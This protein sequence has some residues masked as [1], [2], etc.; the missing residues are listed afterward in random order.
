MKEMF[1]IHIRQ[2]SHCIV[3]SFYIF[4]CVYLLLLLLLIIDT[5]FI[6]QLFLN[7]IILFCSVV[8][9]IISNILLL[10]FM[11]LLSFDHVQ[12]KAWLG[13]INFY[14]SGVASFTPVYQI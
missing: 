8:L 7:V 5:N 10:S 1:T 4:L 12:L 6:T 13:R 2:G 14:I 11:F 3:S 9:I